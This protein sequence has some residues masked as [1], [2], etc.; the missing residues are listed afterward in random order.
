MLKMGLVVVFGIAFVLVLVAVGFDLG[1]TQASDL[2]LLFWLQAWELFFVSSQSTVLERYIH[3]F[4]HPL[5][6]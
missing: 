2:S 3:S 4:I 6:M 1:I 5:G